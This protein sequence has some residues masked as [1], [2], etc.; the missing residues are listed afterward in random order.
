MSHL[1]KGFWGLMAI[2]LLG[3]NACNSSESVEEKDISQNEL[4]V[5]HGKVVQSPLFNAVVGLYM[6]SYRESVCTGTLIH[7]SWVLTAAHCVANQN[8]S[9]GPTPSISP[10]DV[11]IGIGNNQD[12][13]KAHQYPVERIIFHE[14]YGKLS[15]YDHDIALIKLAVPVSSYE[16]FP[17]PPLSPDRSI[18]R[19]RINSEA[20]ELT[21]MG[22]GYDENRDY[23]VKKY[24]T[25]PLLENCSIANEDSVNGCYY[26][27]KSVPLGTLYYDFAPGGSCNGDSGGPDFVKIDEFPHYAVA[28]LTSYGDSGCQR[29][30]VDTLVQDYYDS[31]ILYHA[32]EVKSYHEW[33]STV[34]EEE[35]AEGH[36]SDDHLATCKMEN[37][38]KY[39]C[40]ITEE[41][42]WDCAESC[43]GLDRC[44][45]VCMDGE[46][47]CD[48]N[49]MLYACVNG[50]W[51]ISACP[52]SAPYCREGSCSEIAVD[53][54]TFH[55]LEV[56]EE[57]S[58]STGYGRI[59]IPSGNPEDVTAAYMACTDDI[60]VPVSQWTRVDASINE[61]CNDCGNNYEYMAEGYQSV[62]GFNFC[63]FVFEYNNQAMACNPWQ[64][65]E[66]APIPLDAETL[67]NV[68]GTRYFNQIK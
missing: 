7:P 54:C 46:S 65:G 3:F 18:T 64:T 63:T 6:P 62:S 36:C 15:G 13:L 8:G 27:N 37:S 11:T 31:F 20:I 57:T 26:Y 34:S 12:E 16:A 9:S 29:Y 41:N 25:V 30:S 50:E 48:A 10:N 40:Y 43:F 42:K 38:V 58:A 2:S 24:T 66:S 45:E 53:W 19:D 56:D 55:W 59:L 22:F 67:L 14:E 60:S 23:G 32:P 44:V 47:N 49:G 35:L 33:R 61:Q 5:T 4:A 28:G 68:D 52:D 39:A 17:L 21:V 51:Q 1:R